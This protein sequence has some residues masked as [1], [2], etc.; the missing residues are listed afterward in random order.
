[1][2]SPKGGTTNS[3][4][5]C[6]MRRA[7]QVLLI[8]TFLAFS[9]LAMMAVH[10]LGHVVGAICTGATVEK[11]VLHPLAIS[12]TDVGNIR[13][14]LV[15]IWSGPVIG[16][17]LPL[18]MLFVIRQVK[19]PCWPLAKFFAGFCLAANG[20]YIGCGSFERIG[21]AGDLL[22]HGSPAWTLW[23][24]GVVTIPYG[25]WLW[26]RLGPTFGLGTAKGEV[27]RRLAYL[28]AGLLALTVLVELC[29]SPSH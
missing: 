13:N 3:P 4:P 28:S 20:A 26:N 9:C 8:V 16:A 29:F 19:W 21:D 27:N 18:V 25:F 14:P 23:L 24:F 11:V 2:L 10:E 22:S 12:R 17:L 5:S 6:L 7:H 15:V 1:M